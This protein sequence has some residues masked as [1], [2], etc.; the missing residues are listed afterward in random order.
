MLAKSA[1]VPTCFAISSA[2]PAISL[3]KAKNLALS[4]L[5]FLPVNNSASN[6]FVIELS[7]FNNPEAIFSACSKFKPNCF[8]FTTASATAAALPP[9]DNLIAADVLDTSF[10]TSFSLTTNLFREA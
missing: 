5:R 8:A 7:K 10:K 3:F 6:S 1:D 4:K 2:A 9:N